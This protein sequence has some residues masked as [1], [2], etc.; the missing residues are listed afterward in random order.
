EHTFSGRFLSAP[1]TNSSTSPAGLLAASGIADFTASRICIIRFQSAGERLPGSCCSIVSLTSGPIK[2]A[3]TA[4]KVLGWFSAVPMVCRPLSLQVFARSSKKPAEKV[5]REPADL[6][7][8]PEG[9]PDAP[10]GQ[11][12]PTTR[13][14]SSFMLVLCSIGLGEGC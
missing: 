5:W 6:P 2:R 13:D 12:F 9:L 8:K 7:G 11:G 14:T 1:S 3:Q 10:L 4:K